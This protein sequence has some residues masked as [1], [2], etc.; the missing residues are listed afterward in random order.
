MQLVPSVYSLTDS[1]VESVVDGV[2]VVPHL[3][4][5]LA[6]A[7]VDQA[8]QSLRVSTLFLGARD[9]LL[10]VARPRLGHGDSGQSK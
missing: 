6:Q 10:C 2:E 7:G 3:V 5:A 4:G 9:V 1:R 8:P